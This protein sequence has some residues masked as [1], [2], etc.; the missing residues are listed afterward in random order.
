MADNFGLKLGIDGEKAF[1]NAL[2]DINSSFKVLGSEMKL[3]S[4]Q[5]DKTD[6]S[7]EAVTARSKVLNKEIETQKEKVELL[8]KALKNSEE[9]FGEND[10]RTQAWA[11]QLNNAK[12][13]LNNL[14][15]ELDEN[16]KALDDTADEFKDAEKKADDFGDELKDTGNDA[17]KAENKFSKVASTVKG[18][19][20]AMGA[21]LA[22]IGTATVAA[23]KKIFDLAEETASAGDVVDKQSQKMSMSAEDYQKLAYAADLSGTNMKT[24]QKAQKSLLS[25]GSKLD[26]VDALKEC[27]DSSDVAAKATELFGAKTAQELLPMLNQGSKGIE[28]M[29]NQA[30]QYGLVMSNEAVTASAK[31]QDSL[32][33]LQGT[34]SGVKNRIVSELL[35][36]IT[37]I[38]DGLSGLLA[39]QKDAKEKIQTGAQELVNKLGE[40]LPNIVDIIMSLIGA[41]AEIAPTIIDAL[42]QGI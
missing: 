22:A 37:S 27:A 42:V 32:A 11:T 4:S 9:S 26:L 21:A 1:K 25:S 33:T 12:A 40:I 23:G 34:F 31:F 18:M 36:G 39:G 8:K 41:V 20:K 19:A 10:K 28:D 15:K 16:E 14:N 30:E 35:P 5:F 24:M 6:K 2:K 3:V 17:D 38:M 29:M 7:E 13:D